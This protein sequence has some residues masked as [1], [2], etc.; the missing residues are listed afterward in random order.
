M[1]I[2]RYKL[3]IFDWD[4]TLSTSTPVVKIARHLKRR[5]DVSYI[6]SRGR[7][8]YTAEKTRYREKSRHMG[9]IYS[10]A[11]WIYSIFYKP[12][13]KPGAL[14]LLRLLRKKHKKIAL[15]SD[16]NKYRL[17]IEVKKLGIEKYFD[18]I[19]SADT[20]KKFKPNPT[21]LFE[22]ASRFGYKKSECIYIG[23]MASDVFTARFA[24][25]PSCVVA[26]GVDPYGILK[27]AKPDYLIRRLETFKESR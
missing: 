20:I 11:Y 27:K 26:D 16:S 1:L 7:G 15:F 22:T 9:R 13:L 21:G 4:G 14:E 12:S 23:D 17:E 19:L 8:E 24:G 5:Y 25:M 6:K 10:F 18:F 2:D 3:Y